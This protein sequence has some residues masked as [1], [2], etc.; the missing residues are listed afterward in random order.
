MRLSLHFELSEFT[1]SQTAIR[2]GIDN[3]PSDV[4]IENL[5]LLCTHIL[6]PIR[7]GLGKPLRVSSGYRSKALN[8]AIGGAANSQ[9]ITGQAAD[10]TVQGMSVEEVYQWIKT[11]GIVFDQSIFEFGQWLHISYA[12][13]ARMQSLRAVKVNGKT[14]YLPD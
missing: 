2:K 6:E 5:K 8:K 3:T 13:M 10:F 12:T 14:V 9:H 7:T 11:S 1:F 4:V